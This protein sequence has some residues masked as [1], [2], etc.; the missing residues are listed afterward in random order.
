MF[1]FCPLLFGVIVRLFRR[2]GSLLLENLVLRQQVC[3]LKRRNRRP[4]LTGM[5]RLFWV[6]VSRL[7]SDW[8]ASLLV[9]KPETVVEWHRRGFR[10]YWQLKSKAK[11]I[12]RTPISKELQQ[13]I[14]RMASENSNWGAPRIHGELMMLGFDVAERTISRWM[15]RQPRK[16]DPA[17]R[18]LSFLHNHREAVV[19]MDFF[20][21]PTIT[22]RVLYASSLLRMTADTFSV[23]TSPSIRRVAGS[24]NRYAKRFLMR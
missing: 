18:W 20:T 24:L 6:A 9:V 14:F 21:M 4:K 7:W 11:P 3:V 5:D 1:R 8:K 15:R 13:L 10:L 2:R 17:Q 19:A 23:S 22:F 12:G 16:P